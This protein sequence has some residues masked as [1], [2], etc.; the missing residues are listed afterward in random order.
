MKIPLKAN[1]IS[2]KG[3]VVLCRFFCGS[4][5]DDFDVVDDDE[6]ED[7]EDTFIMIR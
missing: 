5:D 3:L 6:D 7:D 1:R 2:P 4:V